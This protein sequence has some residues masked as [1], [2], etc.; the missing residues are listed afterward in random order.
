VELGRVVVRATQGDVP[1]FLAT[2]AAAA[3]GAP[4]AATG[5]FLPGR[6]LRLAPGGEE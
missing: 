6:D 2:L 1:A 4:C 3:G 5:A